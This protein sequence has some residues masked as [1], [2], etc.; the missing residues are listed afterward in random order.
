MSVVE[1]SSI[2]I[3]RLRDVLDSAWFYGARTVGVLG[4]M[5][6]LWARAALSERLRVAFGQ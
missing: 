5:L 6:F 4:L 1:N 3:R 2:R